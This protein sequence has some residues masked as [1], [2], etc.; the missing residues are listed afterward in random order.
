MEQILPRMDKLI[1]ED[2]AAGGVVPYLPLER[3]G[4]KR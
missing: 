1:M 3:R 2:G 4:S